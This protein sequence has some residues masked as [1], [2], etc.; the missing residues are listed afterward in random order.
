MHVHFAFW[1]GA[2]D[3]NKKKLESIQRLA[4]CKILGVMNTS[5]DA[6]E[7]VNIISQT[8]PLE[9]RRRQE[10][11]NLYHKC[12]KWSNKFPNHNL[13]LAY[14]CWKQVHIFKDKDN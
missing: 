12:V 9:L 4:L 3:T 13:T 10:E 8:P 7:T 14:K 11:V 6:Y 1:N 5:A 2:A